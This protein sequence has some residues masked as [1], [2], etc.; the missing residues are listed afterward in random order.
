MYLA[1]YFI[2][3]YQLT[4]LYSEFLIDDRIVSILYI[5]I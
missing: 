4:E 5:I 2:N 3:I 1:K